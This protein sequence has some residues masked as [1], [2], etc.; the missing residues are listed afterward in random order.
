MKQPTNSPAARAFVNAVFGLPDLSEQTVIFYLP[1]APW[2]LNGVD[3]F[4][5]DEENTSPAAT[6]L[7]SDGVY[8]ALAPHQVVGYMEWDRA[9]FEADGFCCCICYRKITDDYAVYVLQAKHRRTTSS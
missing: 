8:G 1:E 4:I 9:F 2:E 5:L 3:L 6:L 7:E